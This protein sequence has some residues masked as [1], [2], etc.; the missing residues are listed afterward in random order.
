MEKPDGN[1]ERT[2]Y[3]DKP[4]PRGPRKR[5]NTQWCIYFGDGSRELSSLELNSGKGNQEGGAASTAV[6]A[7]PV[8]IKHLTL[9]LC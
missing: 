2:Y 9:P 5:S 8:F 4:I 6:I 7:A 1:P 3:L